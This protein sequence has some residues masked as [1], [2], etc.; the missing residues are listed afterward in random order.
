M[1]VGP[2]HMYTKP[3]GDHAGSMRCALHNAT[4]LNMW[5]TACAH[6][7]LTAAVHMAPHNKKAIFTL[8]Y[9]VKSSS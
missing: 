3:H 2:F 5:R 9:L 1:Q 8:N 4:C 7:W 6:M